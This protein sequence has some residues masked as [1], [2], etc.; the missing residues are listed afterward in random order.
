M[1]IVL[2]GFKH[3][4]SEVAGPSVQE[5]SFRL[6]SAGCEV[7]GASFKLESGWKPA[8]EMLK[9]FGGNAMRR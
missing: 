9:D 1:G 4:N 6:S 3:K 8:V 7:S 5:S 2:S